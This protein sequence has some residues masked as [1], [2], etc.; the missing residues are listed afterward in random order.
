VAQS[1]A[2]AAAEAVTGVVADCAAVVLLSDGAATLA[3]LLGAL[4]WRELIDLAV[5]RGPHELIAATREVE[6][7]DPDGVV[8]PRYK[9]HDDASAVVLVR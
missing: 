3:T 8:W 6:A 5:A 9:V 7:R 1:D 2:R 4:T